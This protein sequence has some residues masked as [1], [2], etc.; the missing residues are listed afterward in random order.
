MKRFIEYIKNDYFDYLCVSFFYTS[1]IVF[2]FLA[3]RLTIYVLAGNIYPEFRD[4]GLLNYLYISLVPDF[5]AFLMLLSF[6][7]PLNFIIKNIKARYVITS[8]FLIFL[9]IF[10]V[11]SSGFF[12]SYQTTFQAGFLGDDQSTDLRSFFMSFFS[13]FSIWIY[14]KLFIAAA[15]LIAWGIYVY[16][17]NSAIRMGE[18]NR[19][20]S[21]GKKR[22][23]FI[24]FFSPAVIIIIITAVIIVN[25]E[26]GYS[27]LSRKFYNI[28]EKKIIR[29]LKE[30]SMNPFYNLFFSTGEPADEIIIDDDNENFSFKFNT[31]SLESQK[32]YNRIGQ[33]PQGKKY[34][35]ILYF[36]ESFPSK[37]YD[38]KMNGRD[39]VPS[40][41]RLE[42]NS[43]RL[44]NHYAN[45]PLSANAMLSVFMSAYGMN[46]RELVVQ[47]YSHINLKSISQILK[48]NGYRTFLVH[49]GMLEYAGQK[50][51][52][53]T[54][55][56]DR[57][58]DLRDL[59]KPPF[60]E[61][62]GWGLD[63]RALIEPCVEFA[64]ENT[65][66]PFFMAVF[67]V[68]P[69]HPYPIPEKKFQIT[70]EISN[71]K[72]ERERVWLD[73]LNS[74]HYADAVLGQM[75]DRLEQEGLLENTLFFV[76]ADHG[77]AFYQHRKNYNHPL[78]IYE[79]NV[80]VPFLIYNKRF[81][82]E[83]VVFNGITRHIDILPTVLDML[84]IP[85]LPEQEGVSILSYRRE[86]FAVLHTSYKEDYMGIRD[87][88]WK[89][90]YRA[91]DGFEELFDLSQDPDEKDNLAF[92]YKDISRRY[93]NVVIDAKK[94]KR[95]YY[96]RI[97]NP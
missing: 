9:S 85:P 79:E 54:R 64:K 24:S 31:D 80:H 55:R 38:I 18:V 34:N 97:L 70:G 17:L 89:Y 4:L 73:Y 59:K 90:I 45:Y 15:I 44:V 61:W 3:Y 86:Q 93:R 26:K 71:M 56:F 74:L 51:F 65:G 82:K 87:S 40:W 6:F 58:T 27:M 33:I 14:L 91:S 57:I 49:T 32:R 36:F 2:L 75:V 66:N 77:E 50:R 62:V 83:P 52:L 81:F 10:I 37:Y 96:R 7:I 25:P 68:S 43:L 67:P 30:I 78:Y 41:K 94:Y 47:R 95:E 5:K 8:G 48:E 76:F 39:V 53:K 72:G 69:H 63:D 1:F 84:S 23:I 12:N 19:Y 16:S 20:Y 22:K 11:I 60:T 92:K 29:N 21:R 35:I 28:P 46:S 42:K 13:E 88:R